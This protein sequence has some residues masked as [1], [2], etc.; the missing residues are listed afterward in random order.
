MHTSTHT[1]THAHAYTRTCER[2]RSDNPRCCPKQHER[3]R[4]LR[5]QQKL[6]LEFSFLFLKEDHSKHGAPSHTVTVRHT[7]GR[8]QCQ[9]NDPWSVVWPTTRPRSFS[10]PTFG[11]FPAT[12]CGQT[13]R[14]AFARDHAFAVE[15]SYLRCAHRRALCHSAQL[16]ATPPPLEFD[17]E[18]ASLTAPIAGFFDRLFDRLL[19]VLVELVLSQAASM[20]TEVC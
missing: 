19:G 5:R 15:H 11:L 3:T 14:P 6:E 2:V 1:H 17:F 13:F 9:R 8:S 20:G 18:A 12:A 4:Y 10:E 16:L 7:L